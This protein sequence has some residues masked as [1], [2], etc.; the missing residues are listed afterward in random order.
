M[1]DQQVFFKQGSVT[2]GDSDERGATGAINPV[3]DGESVKAATLDR[4][5]ENLRKRTE[6]LRVEAEKTQY[7]LDSNM[8][9]IIAGGDAGGIGATGVDVPRIVDWV[10]DGATGTFTIS[11]PI[12]V[13]PLNT[14]LEDAQEIKSYLFTAGGVNTG[15]I[16][17]YPVAGLTGSGIPDERAYNGANLINV[18]WL[19][20]A[21]MTGGVPATAVL[22][23][24]PPHILTLSICSD[25][26]NQVVDLDNALIGISGTMR[27]AGIDYTVTG[28]NTT[29]VDIATLTAVG[30]EDYRLTKTAEREM[31]RLL[32]AHFATFFS[33]NSMAD[34]DTLALYFADYTQTGISP[35]GRRQQIVSNSNVDRSDADL[36]LTSEFPERFPLSIPLCK[37]IGDTLLWLDGTVVTEDA[38]A[39]GVGGQY[40][41][42]NGFT[43]DRAIDGWLGGTYTPSSGL[44]E[45]LCQVSIANPVAGLALSVLGGPGQQGIYTTGG[46]Q[47]G[48]A[49]GAG[50]EAHGGDGD[51]TGG[52]SVPG[53]GI[54]AYGGGSPVGHTGGVGVYAQGASGAA[55]VYGVGGTGGV[56]IW[57]ESDTTSPARA[58]FHIEPQNATPTTKA[59][60]DIWF[61]SVKH[62]YRGYDGATGTF[63][64]IPGEGTGQVMRIPAAAAHPYTYTG[65]GVTGAVPW[66]FAGNVYQS[67]GASAGIAASINGLIPNKSTI[68]NV[69]A[70]VL[71]GVNVARAD[72]MSLTL[73]KYLTSG[74]AL[75]VTGAT[76]YTNGTG[77]EQTITPVGAIAEVVDFATTNY[78][79]EIGA[80]ASG[81]GIAGGNGCE[82][83][84]YAEITYSL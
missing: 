20:P 76:G 5:E 73:Y 4:P 31:H 42:E 84:Y 52:G 54:N 34:G 29:Y 80:G 6:V 39:T 68:T 71:P 75:T 18:V 22:S 77:V 13:Q 38:S 8:K 10:P 81:A 47:T 16:E 17:I 45:F 14:V 25:A 44:L 30:D 50:L 56:G 1:A 61:D 72:N 46:S 24:D 43:K 66:R 64:F 49:G 83:F 27:A 32:P 21:G 35:D 37:R 15:G 63:A 53:N 60:G 23:G 57:A 48:L 79:L 74:G 59:E 26:S 19:A 70:R 58:A 51:S 36:F 28:I 40:F 9:W 69:T 78:F 12:V 11:A 82:E 65:L 2:T 41:G 3:R 7:L 55:G 62:L 33:S 67:V